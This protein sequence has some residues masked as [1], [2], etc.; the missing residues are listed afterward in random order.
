MRKDVL[1]NLTTRSR[2]VAGQMVYK[3]APILARA[4]QSTTNHSSHEAPPFSSSA[5]RRAVCQSLRIRSRSPDA[6]QTPIGQP[7]TETPQRTF[8]VPF[9]PLPNHN[10]ALLYLRINGKAGGAFMVDT[11]A[12]GNLISESLVTRLGL[13]THPAGGGTGTFGPPLNHAD[14]PL[15]TLPL[16]QGTETTTLDIN[17]TN[18]ATSFAV[19][20]PEQ[21]QIFFADGILGVPFLTNGAVSFDFVTHSMGFTYPGSLSPAQVKVLGFGGADGAILPLTPC[22]GD[23]VS[24]PATLSDGRSSHRVDLQVDTGGGSTLIPFAVAN[25]LSLKSVGTTQI[26]GGTAG[27]KVLGQVELP[28]LSLGG[29]QLT[30]LTVTATNSLVNPT[31]SKPGEEVQPHLGMDILKNYRILLDYPAKVMYLQP[32]TSKELLTQPPNPK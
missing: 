31:A 29:L 12:N 8:P 30:N 7:P 28:S 1:L 6:Q 15:I 27:H 25:E 17:L 10:G 18:G 26:D 13:K 2:S 9:I 32:N 11:G 14:V 22:N 3:E 21:L 20:P 5:R 16:T 4:T 23:C 19:A 24:V